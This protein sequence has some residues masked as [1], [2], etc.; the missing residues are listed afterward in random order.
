MVRLR[1]VRRPYG[2]LYGT[3]RK[4]WKAI[5]ELGGLT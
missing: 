4:R 3:G 5:V 2:S 1:P